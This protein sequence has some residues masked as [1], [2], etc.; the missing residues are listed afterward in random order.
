MFQYGSSCKT[1]LAAELA[2]VRLACT[3]QGLR[4][5]HAVTRIVPAQARRDIRTS[6]AASGAGEDEVDATPAS[7]AFANYNVYKGKAALQMTIL[8]PTWSGTQKG[9]FY[10]EREGALLLQFAPIGANTTGTN[11]GQRKYDWSTNLLFAMSPNEMGMFLID[12]TSFEAFHDPNKGKAGE[13]TQTKKLILSPSGN[14]DGAFFLNF[15]QSGT[16]AA[17][18]MVP[19]LPNE[20]AVIKSLINYA[21]P[22]KGELQK[23]CIFGATSLSRASRIP[24]ASPLP[25]LLSHLVRLRLEYST[26]YKT[27][28][29]SFRSRN[30]KGDLMQ[31]RSVCQMLS[32]G[33]RI[34]H[35]A[36]RKVPAQA[37]R[38]IRTSV[39]ASWAGEDMVE[40]TPASKAF[41]KYCVYKGKAALQMTIIPPTWSGTQKGNFYVEKE[42]KLMLRFAP[43][44][45]NPSGT[46]VGQRNYDWSANLCFAMSPNEMGMFLTEKTVFEAFHDPNK[47]K[48]G[49]GSQTKSLKLSP[50]GNNDGA[51]F[52]I[53]MQNGTKAAKVM[54]P[55]G[56]SELA[57]I[58]S[59]VNYALPRVLGFDMQFEK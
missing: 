49:E 20:L 53:F 10:V 9:N 25:R 36:T 54:I 17:K 22:R 45:A 11:V 57:V 31:S 26:F 51:F 1:Q 33:L 2:G 37:R 43:I 29:R 35:A 47:G 46:N 8:P 27:P 34:P 15:N 18:V 6:V 32:R 4:V 5:P 41:A 12:K 39:A 28:S 55:L 14:N 7:K 19:L 23:H 44:G 56:P 16:K 13:G 48:A 30:L 42:G 3:L 59:L 24:P 38:D 40:A 50:S 58:K 52:F 21:L